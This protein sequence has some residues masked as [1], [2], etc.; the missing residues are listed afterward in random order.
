[1]GAM[2]AKSPCC[3]AIWPAVRHSGTV[4]ISAFGTRRR[5]SLWVRILMHEGKF[6]GVYSGAR[7]QLKPSLA[8]VGGVLAES[9]PQM[10]LFSIQGIPAPLT[11]PASRAAQRQ[12]DRSDERHERR[13]RR[14]R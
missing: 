14:P 4:Q 7:S 3:C 10:T 13:E 6:L 2:V 11:L 8:D 5:G 9:A 12:P 1:M